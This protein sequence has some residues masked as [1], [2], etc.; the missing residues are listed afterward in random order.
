MNYRP[1]KKSHGVTLSGRRGK[2][3]LGPVYRLQRGTSML[4][5]NLQV[6]T[7]SDQFDSI[8][9]S[10]IWHDSFVQDF[11]W[12]P[13]EYLDARRN[14]IAC[15]GF[16]LVRVLLILCYTN[17]AIEIIGFEPETCQIGSQHYLEDTEK[18]VVVKRRSADLEFGAFSLHCAAIACRHV[19]VASANDDCVAN[20]IGED[21]QL[22]PP[23]NIDWRAILDEAFRPRKPLIG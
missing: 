22:L 15:R 13:A 7:S 18:S 20:I 9:S 8:V 21:G 19:P 11:R 12:I 3:T 14:I 10:L 6:I 17:D 1:L 23:Y 2:Q 5:H 4:D 16:S